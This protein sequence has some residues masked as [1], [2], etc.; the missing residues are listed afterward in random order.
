MK[1]KEIYDY[2][3][4]YMIIKLHLTSCKNTDKETKTNKITGS[5]DKVINIK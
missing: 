4:I 3:F 1:F 2:K 5:P